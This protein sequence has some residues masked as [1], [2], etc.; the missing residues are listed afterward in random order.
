MANAARVQ[1]PQRGRDVARNAGRVVQGQHPILDELGDVQTL[2]ALVDHVG[3][4]AGI[5]QK[6]RRQN[7]RDARA[8]R[9]A[10]QL[11]ET[12]SQARAGSFDRARRQFDDPLDVAALVK[13]QIAR[14]AVALR[15]GAAQLLLRAI[16]PRQDVAFAQI[17]QIPLRAGFGAVHCAAKMFNPRHRP[18]PRSAGSSQTACLG[19]AALQNRAAA[20]RKAGAKPDRKVF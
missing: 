19:R 3:R 12:P 1:K 5:V 17:G 20:L 8:G 15:R 14:E 2:D 11:I 6:P 13:D 16:A 9:Q 18:P 10:Q 7:P 4:L